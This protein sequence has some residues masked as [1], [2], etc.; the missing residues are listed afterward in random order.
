MTGFGR[1]TAGTGQGSV[2]AE[3]RS[4][5]GRFLKLSVKLPERLTV[6]EA[7]FEALVKEHVTRGSVN[8]AIRAGTDGEAER[9]TTVNRERAAFFYGELDS[10]RK[11]VGSCDP[12]SI[13]DIARLPGVIVEA[14]PGASDPEALLATS[15]EALRG[16]LDGLNRM[17]NSEGTALAADL[18]SRVREL[19]RLNE[20]A[21]L[22]APGVVDEYRVRLQ[23]RIARLL[24]NSG[25]APRPE[26]IAREVANHADR[27]DISEETQRLGHHCRTFLATLGTPGEAGRKLDFLAQEMLRE[28]N[29]L[30]SK[31]N[32]PE[33]G[34]TVICMKA[35][36]EKIK[37]Q[38]QNVE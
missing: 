34:D 15:L 9:V 5:N 12:L 6:F 18:S 27:C 20:S 14:E 17:R 19:E 28:A 16:A 38:V 30:G 32:D 31:A 1:A 29:T 13:T 22:R 11:A 2:V 24:E 4:V 23:E 21:R 26:D 36:I 3:V 37:E 25:V 10:L 35:E 33:L 7:K 8:V